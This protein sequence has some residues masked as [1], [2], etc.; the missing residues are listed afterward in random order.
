[1]LL[2]VIVDSKSSNNCISTVGNSASTIKLES[3]TTRETE[4][5]HFVG[6]TFTSQNLLVN[7]DP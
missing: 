1:M 5:V 2:L 7:A 3:S 4:H 6:C